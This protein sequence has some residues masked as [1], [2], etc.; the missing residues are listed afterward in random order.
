MKHRVSHN[1]HLLK[2]KRGIP[3]CENRVI[4]ITECGGD[5]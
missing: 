3:L 4:P 1:T 2:A 5:S